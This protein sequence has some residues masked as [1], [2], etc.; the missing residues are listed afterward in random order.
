MLPD[1]VLRV[2]SLRELP[3]YV[4]PLGVVVLRCTLRQTDHLQVLLFLGAGVQP[5]C[6]GAKAGLHLGQGVSL[7]QGHVETGTDTD[8]QF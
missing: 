3:G 4:S 7:L 5:G 8:T 6:L 1:L 2:F